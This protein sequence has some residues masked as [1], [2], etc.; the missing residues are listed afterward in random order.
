MIDQL[1]Y[2]YRLYVRENKLYL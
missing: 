1:V 2:L